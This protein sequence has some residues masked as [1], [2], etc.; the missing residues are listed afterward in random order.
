[1]TLVGFSIRT[2]YSWKMWEATRRSRARERSHLHA[3]LSPLPPASLL[4][5]SEDTRQKVNLG[6]IERAE[7]RMVVRYGW[8]FLPSCMP[9]SLDRLVSLLPLW[10]MTLSQAAQQSSVY[11][12]IRDARSA[13]GG[14]SLR[15]SPLFEVDLCSMLGGMGCLRQRCGFLSL[16]FAV[17]FPDHAAGCTIVVRLSVLLLY[18]R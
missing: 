5:L 8:T 7:V 16:C 1:M 18:H 17:G 11:F 4:R 15:S 14:R 12:S 3:R 10:M 6:F 2:K 13:R 9:C